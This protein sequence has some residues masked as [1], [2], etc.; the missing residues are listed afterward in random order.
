MLPLAYT[1][2]NL[3]RRRTRTILTLIGI[4]LIT[5]QVILVAGFARALAKSATATA[6]PHVGIL[7]G[8]TGEHD[9]V[10]SVI[11][12]GNAEAVAAGL[13]GVAVVGDSRAVS[14]EL[15]SASRRGVA[16]ALL[17]GVTPM[18]YLVHERLTVVEGREPEAPYEVLAGR[19]A[20]SRM[21]MAD[22]DMAIG[23]TIELEGRT[24]TVVGHFAA[25]GTVLEA[26]L[27]VRLDDLVQSVG[28]QDVSCVA[29]RWPDARSMKRGRLWTARNAVSY[30]VSFVEESALYESLQRQ[31]DPIVA[32]S[33]L[34]AL[35]VLIA[36]IFACT[37]TMFAAVLA[38]TREMGALRAIGFRPSS[39][40]VSLIMESLILGLVGGL[41]GFWA[42]GFFQEIPMKFPMGAFSIDLS[43][44]M[45]LFG[46]GAALVAGLIGGLIPA[47]RTMR[48]PLV[49]AL[50]GRL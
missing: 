1:F 18:A 23:N 30:E 45:R 11:S 7:V 34:M 6:S 42:A 40:G 37:N 13:P 19:L 47:W 16:V 39:I 46:L 2:R 33:W 28:R 27:W 5:L 38:R 48:M 44:S 4:A 36:G 29:A 49:D 17:R 21:G 41:I 8:A 14:V 43:P 10:R 24:W 9:L 3:W 32:L 12:R 20:A 35:L 26:E 25:P 31:L 50:G 22:S 15:H